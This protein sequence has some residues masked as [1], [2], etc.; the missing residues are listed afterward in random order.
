MTSSIK[1]INLAGFGNTGVT[2]LCDF[3]TDFDEFDGFLPRV[4]EGGYVKS[5]ISFLSLFKSSGLSMRSEFADLTID[6]LADSITGSSGRFKERYTARGFGEQGHLK[7]RA[8]MVNQ[9][10]IGESELRSVI[11]LL[12]RDLECNA[13]GLLPEYVPEA[14]IT[15]AFEKFKTAIVKAHHRNNIAEKRP[16]PKVLF[17]KNDPPA[18]LPDVSCLLFDRSI[19][20]C[21]EPTDTTYD[22]LRHY[23]M[24]VTTANVKWHIK[25]YKN[26][27][28]SFISRLEARE[29]INFTERLRIV[30]FSDFVEKSAVRTEV[31]RFAL[32]DSSLSNL[33][34]TSAKFNA[35]N[36]KKNIG[37]GSSL[38]TSDQNL[39]RREIQ[40][41]YDFFIEKLKTHGLIFQ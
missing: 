38:S 1:T 5:D 17:F 2:A 12:N 10:I 25:A 6:D 4:H 16:Q 26:A 36:S 11:K 15:V 31:V 23:G 21:R 18:A 27:L 37:H 35:N 9:K 34:A 29:D 32:S 7:N 22:L 8:Q 19:F 24:D 14:K 41:Y 30:Q 33:N 3:L 40:P 13:R 28:T 39:I 20:I